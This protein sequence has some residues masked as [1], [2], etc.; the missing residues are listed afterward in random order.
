VA[1]VVVSAFSCR[2]PV[3]PPPP[4][5]YQL[6][7]W[8]ERSNGAD[9]AE[10][11]VRSAMQSSADPCQDFYQYA[12]GGVL[13][14]SPSQFF[15]LQQTIALSQTRIWKFLDELQRSETPDP[16]TAPVRRFYA[17][18]A[19]ANTIERR[20][21]GPLQQ[22]LREID[23]PASLETFMAVLGHL[24]RRGISVLFEAEVLPDIND[25][26][27]YALELQQGGLGLGE[28]RLYLDDTPAAIAAREM[29]S[30]NLEWLVDKLER[31]KVPPES[32]AE[33]MEIE[34]ELARR[35]VPGY[36]LNP[37]AAQQTLNIQQLE[38][39]TGLPWGSYAQAIGLGDRFA[40]RLTPIDYFRG[41]GQLLSR[42]STE[43]LRLYLRARAFRAT[44]PL[45]DWGGPVLPYTR[46]LNCVSETEEAAGGLIWKA[47]SERYNGEQRRRRA[48]ELWHAIQSAFE[49][50]I[51]LD[52]WLKPQLPGL[53]EKAR[54]VTAF[55][56]FPVQLNQSALFTSAA[57]DYFGNVMAARTAWFD[58]RIGLVA[59]PVDAKR[60]LG[61]RSLLIPAY[62]PRWNQIVIPLAVLQP[63]VFD[64]RFPAALN[65]GGLGTVM[66]HELAHT[67]DRHGRTLDAR[68][69]AMAWDDAVA[70]EMAQHAACLAR[71]YNRFEAA[72]RQY[73]TMTGWLQPALLVD[74]ERTADEN[75]AD[76][77]GVRVA[78][79]AFKLWAAEHTTEASVGL[80]LTPD[81]LFF[82]AFAQNW[83][84]E[85]D[86]EL[87]RLLAE[88][89]V[90]VPP[91]G[92][93]NA[94]VSAL[95]EFT[96]AFHCPD[97][98]R[99]HPQEVC[100]LP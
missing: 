67:I 24:H 89:D 33:F 1:V 81:Q 60:W 98:S 5:L 30:R 12:C 48:E 14:K 90:H 41:L 79:G 10:Q 94:T 18:C 39:L 32:A 87:R 49:H 21:L 23:G 100:Q 76:A 40:V 29:Y 36:R 64:P 25:P 11:F 45:L 69:G 85:P 75:L 28:P 83:C 66:A 55:V 2:I 50:G 27:R 95:P 4:F 44:A 59:Q 17:S 54:A 15:G 3:E 53:L 93:V 37:D 88:Y 31:N 19:D 57:D 38:E 34:T 26:T 72:P 22:L 20:R 63:P 99:M 6:A 96:E 51:E 71:H 77:L 68:G 92:R 65:F 82:V 13:G 86:K 16:E 80:G 42:H 84:G 52:G 78:F 70:D 47:Y 9:S 7:D 58:Y 35:F 61:P 97:G 46:W 8:E 73:S 43:I 56:G 91:R 74:S 62:L